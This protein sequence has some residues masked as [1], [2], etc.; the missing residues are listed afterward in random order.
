MPRIYIWNRLD[1]PLRFYSFCWHAYIVLKVHKFFSF[2]F[3]SRHP[4]RNPLCSILC[5]NRNHFT[6]FVL[7]LNLCIISNRYQIQWKRNIRKSSSTLSDAIEWIRID[8]FWID[9][10]VVV[11]VFE[12]F[13]FSFCRPEQVVWI[14]KL[15]KARHSSDSIQLS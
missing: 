14:E 9:V 3:H 11:V 2:F 7:K 10:V 4:I 1:M 6:L 5:H 15:T 8:G 12:A 13:F